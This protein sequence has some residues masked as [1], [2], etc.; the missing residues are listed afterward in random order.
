MISAASLVFA[1]LVKHWKPFPILEP[2]LYGAPGYNW[3]VVY[4]EYESLSHGTPHIFLQVW[5][6]RLLSIASY[7]G[8]I[9]L[10]LSFSRP[11]QKS[12]ANAVQSEVTW[13]QLGVLLAPFTIAYI[14]LL[15]L[16]A[17][18]VANTGTGELFD[19]YALGLLV[20]A[21]ICLVRYYQDRIQPNLPLSCAVPIAVMAVY[22]VLVTHN[23]FALY[24]ARVAI[25]DELRAAG[26]PDTSVDN[27]WEHNIDVEIQ[28]AGYVNNP[29]MVLPEHAYVPTPPLPAGTCLM[30]Y[31]DETPMIHPVYG[32]ALDPDACYG[33]APFAPVHYSRWFAFNPGTLYVVNYLAASKP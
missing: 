28:H 24:R 15:I 22:G 29:G 7:G 9:G 10:I 1:F 27:G 2:T 17:V 23:T 19:R 33:R 6:R 8:L 11:E 5:M 13:R 16:R 26:I 25:A 4:G 3:I 30:I 21:V 20:V 12:R 18:S 31:Q 32:I 14:L